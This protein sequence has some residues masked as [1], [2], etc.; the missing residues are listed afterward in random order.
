MKSQTKTWRRT[1]AAVCLSAAALGGT[2]AAAQ[3]SQSDVVY[4][5]QTK[6]F[7]T[8]FWGH[9]VV[10]FSNVGGSDTSIYWESATTHAPLYLPKGSPPNCMSRAFV[11]FRLAVTDVG[12]SPVQVS[13]PYGP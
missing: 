3:A 6:S 8:W 1:L 7:A 2:A 10:C 12:P 5:N 9:T 4:P 11:G 13:F